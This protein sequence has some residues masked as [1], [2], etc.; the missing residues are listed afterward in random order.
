MSKAVCKR[1]NQAA[2]ASLLSRSSPKLKARQVSLLI[3]AGLLCTHTTKA[4]ALEIGLPLSRLSIASL[5]INTIFALGLVLFSIRHFK[6]NHR[7][8]GLLQKNQ[9][10]ASALLAASSATWYWDLESDLVTFSPPLQTT[11]DNRKQITPRDSR[12][13]AYLLPPDDLKHTNQLML[14]AQ[15]HCLT[16]FQQACR[17]KNNQEK[18]LSCIVSGSAYGINSKGQPSALTG[19]ILFSR[20]ETLT[21]ASSVSYRTSLPDRMAKT[22][23]KKPLQN[24]VTASNSQIAKQLLIVDDDPFIRQMLSGLLSNIKI[25]AILASSGEE[26]LSA[27]SEHHIDLVLMDLEMPGG[28][29]RDILKLIRGIPD[30][31]CLPVISMTAGRPE[32]QLGSID[33]SG[34]NAGISKPIDPQKLKRILNH[35]LKE[36]KQVNAKEKIEKQE[37]RPKIMDLDIAMYYVEGNRELLTALLDNIHNDHYHDLE[38]FRDYQ[39]NHNTHDAQRLLHTLKGIAGTIGATEL[40][41]SCETLENQEPYQK[42]A[43]ATFEQAFLV[44]MKEIEIQNGTKRIKSAN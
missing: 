7:C 19:T 12:V 10:E 43:L 32:K 40:K 24:H 11:L 27:L 13:W 2:S 18:Y 42:D 9:R 25:N 21:S 4:M 23:S 28:S 44:L 41:E 6:I 36:E 38:K 16:Q 37:E 35:Y 5:A 39:Q 17:L 15:T 20:K 30:Y 26:A 31:D 14:E 1:I 22:T 3:V 33:L 34:F 8:K 29:G